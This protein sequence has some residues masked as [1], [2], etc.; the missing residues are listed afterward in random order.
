[1]WQTSLLHFFS[2][3]GSCGQVIRSQHSE[4]ALDSGQNSECLLHPPMAS[5]LMQTKGSCS[6]HCSNSQTR[7][8]QGPQVGGGGGQVVR[9]QHLVQSLVEW[10]IVAMLVASSN[11]IAFDAKEGMVI[12]T[13]VQIAGTLSARAAKQP[14]SSFDHRCCETLQIVPSWHR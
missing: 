8:G 12:R 3:V 13:F 9:S 7:G 11:R 10:Q 4:Q 5:P 6:S 14:P 2:Q 1:M